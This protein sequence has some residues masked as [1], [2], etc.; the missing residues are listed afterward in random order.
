ME[1]TQNKTGDTFKVTGNWETQSKALKTQFTQLTDS[2]VK[3]ETGKEEE[4]VSRLQT[5]LSKSR[6]DVL[7]ILKKTQ[8]EKV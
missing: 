8:T 3:F 7:A 4:L 2:D 1:T 6:E 5:K